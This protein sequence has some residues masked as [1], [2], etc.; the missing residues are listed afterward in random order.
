MILRRKII[1][2]DRRLIHRELWRQPG[3]G[4]MRQMIMD[5]RSVERQPY[6]MVWM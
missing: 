2:I 5:T 6:Q 3:R 4:K 1:R